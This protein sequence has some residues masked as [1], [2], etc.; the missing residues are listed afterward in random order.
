MRIKNYVL[1][2]FFL[3]LG[4]YSCGGDDDEIVVV[5][6]RDRAEQYLIDIDSIEEFLSTHFYNYEEFQADPNSSTFQIEFDTIAGENLDK[7]PLMDQVE[8]KMIY[9]AEDVEYK[10][11]YLKVRE[12]LGDT[13]TFGD[14]AR[15]KYQGILINQD[16]FD[17]SPVPVWFQLPNVVQGFREG[18][19]EFNGAT[20]FT[21]NP[22]GTITFDDFGIG[23][24]F[25]PSGLGY[26]NA[27]VSGINS[28]APLIFKI[29]VLVVNESDQ[30]ED[31]ILNI[32]EDLDD[33][34][35]LYSD[36]TD[37]DFVPDFL[38]PDDDGDGTLTKYEDLDE[39]GDP[40]ND[41]SDNDG[42]PNYLDK[43]STVS[44]QD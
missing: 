36:D 16:E 31:G 39:D 17:S 35:N 32:Y 1:V 10:L 4:F 23:A 7:T 40:R 14:A 24:I 37:E 21:E 29:Q 6:P 25:V 3:V 27:P 28:Y 22:D 19:V 20:G 12:G 43:D 13:P 41:D 30:D 9:D 11:Y 2:L 34:R 18:V 33:D 5:P 26:F 44:T 15:L 42:V 8:Y 38:D